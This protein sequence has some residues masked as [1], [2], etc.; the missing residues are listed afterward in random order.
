MRDCDAA[1]LGEATVGGVASASDSGS[2]MRH[3]P[4]KLINAVC[5][6]NQSLKATASGENRNC[7][8]EPAAVPA[9]NASERH[10]DG[11]SLPNAAN[12]MVN[13]HPARPKPTSAPADNSSMAGEWAFAIS[14]SPTM[15]KAAPPASTR[16]AP[17]RS[18]IA[19]AN[20][21][22]TPHNRFCMASASENTSRPQPFSW[23]MG[24]RK[25]PSAE[26]GPNES[27]AIRQPHT[28]ITP[29]VRQLMREVAGSRVV[30]D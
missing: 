27:V 6:P 7:P 20:G 25:N 4:A 3:R 2:M 24:V 29:G 16:R 26:R 14:T 19:P 18:A 9:P 30:M 10:W 11:N 12:T 8:K 22:A 5:Q 23:D 1:A 21:C 15:Y 17:Y 13:E 28:M